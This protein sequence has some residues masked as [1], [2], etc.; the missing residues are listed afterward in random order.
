MHPSHNDVSPGCCAVPNINHPMRAK[1]PSPPFACSRRLG[2]WL[3]ALLA[4]LSAGVLPVSAHE[5]PAGCT[6][7]G[8]GISLFA[9]KQDA[10]VG[11]TISYSALVFNTP[12]PA[13]LATTVTAGIVTP[14]G[15]TNMIT[16]RRVTLNPGDSDFYTNVVTYKVRAQDVLADS[17]VRATAFDRGLI[18]QNDTDSLGGGFQGVNTE[19][20]FP[21]ILVTKQCLGGVGETGAIT[22]TGTVRNCGNVPLNN[23]TVTNFVNG[24]FIRVIG[25][26]TLNTNESVPFNGSYVPLNPCA[27]TTDTLFAQGTDT[28]SNPSNVVSSA[29]ATCQNT[30]TPGIKVTKFCPAPVAPGQLLTYSGSVSN[31][32]NVTLTNIVVTGDLPAPNTS[33]FTVATLAPGAVAN[34]TGS[35][36]APTN[37][38]TTSSLSARAASVC[39]VAVTDSTSLT[40][41]ILTTPQIVVTALCPTTPVTPAGL[42]TFSGSVRNAGD[43]TLTNVLVVGD[44][45]SA[46][47][48]IFSV[49]SIAPG[50]TV[51]FT[52][53][54]NV[55]A[56]ACATSIRL[57][58]S[59]GSACTAQAATNATS[60][61]CPITTTPKV[62]VTLLCPPTPPATGALITYTGTI[63][64]QGNVT[65][66]NVTL[67]SSQTGG[68]VFTVPS[69]APGA[70]TNFTTSFTAPADACSVT[71]TV[72]VNATD[73]CA[74][75]AVT[76]AATTTCPLVT[77]PKV[78]VTLNCPPGATPLGGTLTYSGTVANT[79]NV[80]LTNVTIINDKTGNTVVFTAP[81][82]PPGAST[83]FTGS[84]VVP[85]NAT[86]CSITSTVTASAND[87]CANSRVTASATSTCPL[88]GAPQVSVTINC[89]PA[90]VALGGTLTFSGTVKNAG[91][92]TLSNVVVMRVA[93][94]SAT[95][96][97]SVATLAPG[98][99]ANFSGSYTVPATDACSTVTTVT[100]TANDQCGGTSVA[101]NNTITCPLL[102]TPRI[103]VTQA[104]PPVAPA[105]GALLTYSGSVS[106]AGNITL[107][108]VTVASSQTPGSPVFTVASLAPGAIRTFTGS[109]TAPLDSCSV[110]STLTASGNDSC[111][112]T[113]VN[114]SV[115]ST[116]PLVTSPSIV[117]TKNCPV[118]PTPAGGILTF[119]GTVTNTGN[120]TLNNVMVVNNQPAAN[121]V[122]IGPITLAPGAGTN[123]SGSYTAPLNTCSVTDTLIATGRDKCTSATVTNSISATCPIQTS[124][125]VAITL[126]CPPTPPVSGGLISYT[127]TVR[128]SGS[129][130]LVNVTVSNDQAVPPTVMTIASLPPG[131]STNFVT[132]FNSPAD[133][134][135]LTTTV[136]VQGADS[137]NGLIAST[138]ATVTCPLVTTP[139]IAVTQECPPTPAT[140]GG[141]LTFTGTVR[142]TGNVTL[143]NVMVSNNRVTGIP[144]TGLVAYYNLNETSGSVVAD[145]S[146]L[147][148]NGA[149]ANAT[150]GAGHTGGGLNFNG[151]SS[152]VDIPNSAS[153][154]F[155]G[156]ITLAAWVRP[157]STN[158]LQDIIAHG[159]TT[160][161]PAGSVFLRIN[162]GKYEVGAWD[163]TIPLYVSV[164]A[165]ASDIG[166]FVLLVGVYD[167]TRWTLYRNGV[168]QD[169]V[170]STVGAQKIDARWAIGSRGG[171]GERFFNGGVDEVRIYNRALTASEVN[172]LLNPSAPVP[173]LAAATLAPGASMP[174]TGS[175]LVPIDS[176]CSVTSIV[177]ATGASICTGANVSAQATNT[178]P[179][180]TSP[181]I[182]VVQSCPS[183]PIL[184]NSTLTYT[185]TVFNIGNSTL[186]NVVVTSDRPAANTVIF[187]VASLAPGASANFSG[188]YQ[189]PTNCCVVTSTVRA[190]G[191]DCNRITVNDSD[192]STCTVT[193]HPSLVVTKT[194]PPQPVGVGDVLK[195]SG[196][197]VNNGDIVLINVMV[198]NTQPGTAGVL[199]GPITLAPGE[200]ANYTASYLVP[201]DFCG[202]DTVTAVGMDA[203]LFTPVVNSVS[204]T[205]PVTLTPRISITKN[206]PA[207]PTPPGGTFTFTGRVSN[208]G[209]VTLANVFVYN[210]EPT[211]N[212]LVL[213]P[214]TLAP[215]ESRDFTGSYTARHCCCIIVDTL[216][217]TGN[218]RCDGRLVTATASAACP[219]LSTPR[220]A[221]T[222]SCP[223]TPVPAGGLFSYTGTVSNPG[224]GVLTNVFVYSRQGAQYVLVAGPIELAAGETKSFSGSYTVTAD[225][226]PTANI[227][228]ASGVDACSTRTVIA[229]ANCA[230]PVIPLA[231]PVVLAQPKMANGAVV[232]TW[233]AQDD[234]DYTVQFRSLS[235]PNWADLNTQVTVN[236][237][238]GIATDN[239]TPGVHRVYRVKAVAK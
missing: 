173:V 168:M 18:H 177:T 233:Q 81:I 153:L 124:P 143:T 62:A 149:I 192:T 116:C 108:N 160:N 181:A 42:V 140:P 121:T 80:T 27:P 47:T 84:Y 55:G 222:Q 201:A 10:H 69:L 20:A 59:G 40:C 194:C 218:A 9:D 14:D 38:S 22:F 161:T 129:V 26:I 12:F 53:S 3:M 134:C 236:G 39:G 235:D 188:S 92:I 29:T 32:G 106:N 200:R 163:E 33:V 19:I 5:E 93:P 199:L 128:N 72:T 196:T 150:F 156:P 225:S 25:P 186:T 49:A 44:R 7:S 97:F 234:V 96:V 45:P 34:F 206:C 115:T 58:A 147:G 17:T 229:R 171:G 91:N 99:S 185:G 182:R 46:S 172:V 162:N 158:G 100:A 23:V 16:L 165:P 52:G 202:D 190:S 83:N 228:I 102:T 86:G 64:N 114:N 226:N 133:A 227:L 75:T 109:F 151:T 111:S 174:F 77:T 122:V 193:T 238:T 136:R 221:V 11:E 209:E 76:S 57:T 132:S 214:I 28:L 205:C 207:T 197:V 68:T 70:S 141:V 131:V 30:L 180:N 31:T 166:N 74:A 41:P 36:L 176:N 178:C 90:P 137:C 119:T 217:A 195:Y 183:G 135:S 152:T 146:G 208:T 219:I 35:Y 123:F 142:N 189:V 48:V 73:A 118:T 94:A 198:T 179:L 60:I 50:V 1:P 88:A 216:T 89:P 232:L 78:S 211:N 104:C 155:S 105:P 95:P 110:A 231:N 2:S 170:V 145:T 66:N 4:M 213:G 21:C 144:T 203:C 127:G 215:G 175:Y 239:V 51:P 43:V 37:C 82:L 101:A 210:N 117:V 85:A 212:T 61:T 113:A 159:Y 220:I 204:S 15:V 230:G 13:C 148:N 56:D 130:T 107:T 167:G 71:T 126:L 24:A 67:T 169:N 112:G 120:V 237:T 79:G 125:Q 103:V 187:T 87:K 63:I 154:N 157:A 191:T 54:Y 164:P 139:N 8:L 224:D 138:N 98:A 65:L 223:A 6:G 184:Q